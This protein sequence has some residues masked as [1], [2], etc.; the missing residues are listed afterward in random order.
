MQFSKI[1]RHSLSLGPRSLVGWW[2]WW[3]WKKQPCLQN[4]SL[5]APITNEHSFLS[6]FFEINIPKGNYTLWLV[7]SLHEKKAELWVSHNVYKCEHFSSVLQDLPG[8]ARWQKRKRK[9]WRHSEKSE[10]WRLGQEQNFYK[11]GAK[12]FARMERNSSPRVRVEQ[13][14]I[15]TLLYLGTYVEA[16]PGDGGGGERKQERRLNNS[17]HVT[18]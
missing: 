14:K 3:W 9:K 2:W 8:I 15:H 7:Y 5:G 18:F 1:L 6:F 11:M 10:P 17:Y 12:Q 13:L 16:E 4:V